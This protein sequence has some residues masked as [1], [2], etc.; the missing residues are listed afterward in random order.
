MSPFE[1]QGE[2]D[3]TKSQENLTTKEGTDKYV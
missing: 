2:K 3:D 1:Y